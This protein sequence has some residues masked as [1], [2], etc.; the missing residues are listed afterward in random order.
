MKRNEQGV[1]HKKFLCSVPH[2][3]LYYFDSDTADSPRGVIDMELYSNISF[4]DNILKLSSGDE[5]LL[6]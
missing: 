3:F 2:V 5:E 6:R 1:W 4:E